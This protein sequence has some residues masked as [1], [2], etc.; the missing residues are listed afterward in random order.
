MLQIVVSYLSGFL[1]YLH[2][3]IF[4]GPGSVV[5]IATE[6]RVGWSGDRIPM[7]LRFSTPVQ[8]GPGTH[9]AF[10]A[11]GTGSFLE[12]KC[13]RGVTLTPHPRLVPWS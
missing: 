12:V 7:G 13:D 1:T 10:C 11:M 4:S 3:I 6:L 8:T 5:G 9:V 2:G